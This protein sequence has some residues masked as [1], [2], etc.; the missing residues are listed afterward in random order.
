MDVTS[1]PTDGGLSWTGNGVDWQV[2]FE[3]PL[4]SVTRQ[5][6]TLPLA[7]LKDDS[8]NLEDLFER[9]YDDESEPES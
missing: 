9:L 1:L 6:S 7:S 4:E 3:T 2:S 8:S 5:L